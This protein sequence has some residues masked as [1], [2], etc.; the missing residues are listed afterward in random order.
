MIAAT[1]NMGRNPFNENGYSSY[2]KSA[3]P[4]RYSAEDEADSLCLVER[5][6]FR[7]SFRQAFKLREKAVY[8][9]HLPKDDNLLKLR[10]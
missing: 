9:V 10:I 8:V 2:E 3:S 1:I 5:N 6:M 4:F 7:A